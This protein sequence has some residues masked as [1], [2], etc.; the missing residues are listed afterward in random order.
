MAQLDTSILYIL[1]N[2]SITCV[3][4][5]VVELRSGS[6]HLTGAAEVARG[7]DSKLST[8]FAYLC[9]MGVSLLQTTEKD[10]RPHDHDCVVY[11]CICVCVA[12][13]LKMSLLL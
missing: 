1:F 7:A 2:P 13:T 5:S 9:K 6:T 4:S 11:L 8:A 12:D 10:A 3:P